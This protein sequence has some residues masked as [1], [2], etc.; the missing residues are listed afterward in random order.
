MIWIL[1]FRLAEITLPIKLKNEELA[2]VLPSFIDIP[3]SSWTDISGS[4]ADRFFSKAIPSES[5][6]NVLPST[7]QEATGSRNKILNLYLDMPV[8]D[9]SSISLTSGVLDCSFLINSFLFK[10]LITLSMGLSVK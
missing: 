3:L 9:I 6:Y 8:I 1:F 7:T 5:T 2:T 4:L 10:K